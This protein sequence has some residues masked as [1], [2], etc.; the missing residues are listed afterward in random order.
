MGLSL[1]RAQGPASTPAPPPAAAAFQSPAEQR[2]AF[3]GVP[4][5]W[6]WLQAEGEERVLYTGGPGRAAAAGPRGRGWSELALDGGAVWILQTESSRGDLLRVPSAGAAP[7]TILSGLENPSGLHA[8]GGRVFWF[9]GAPGV[10][11]GLGWVPAAG[12]RLR[13]RCREPAGTVRALA[14]WPSGSAAPEGSRAGQSPAVLGVD[15][16]RVAVSIPH[17]V[18][19]EFYRIP[20]SGGEPERLAG[21]SDAQYGILSGG[22]FYWTGV[23][24][25]A[26]PNTS[27][28]C[29]RRLSGGE[30]ATVTDWLPGG[31]A[32]LAARGE[33]FYAADALY[34]VPAA[35]DAPAYL[36]TLPGG[37]VVSDGETLLLWPAGT[38]PSPLPL[39]A[40]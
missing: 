13:L 26:D 15:G 7:E 9:E 2:R 14:E 35:L 18:S 38:A 6:V 20:L 31:G 28:R 3:A 21:E 12:P 24:E 1:A 29:V 10:D 32:L 8:D 30:A 22:A 17:A 4:G 33:V 34:R 25:E 27:F 39:H 16:E 19:T 11:P 36:R 5:Q 37:L 23:T 40:R